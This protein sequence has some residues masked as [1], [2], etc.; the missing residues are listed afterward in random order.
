MNPLPHWASKETLVLT[1][2]VAKSM[3][4]NPLEVGESKQRVVLKVVQSPARAPLQLELT[5]EIW[6]LKGPT[7]AASNRPRNNEFFSCDRYIAF[8]FPLQ[9]CRS[10]IKFLFLLVRCFPKAR[11]RVENTNCQMNTSHGYFVSGQAAPCYLRPDFYH[12]QFA[13][14]RP[15]DRRIYR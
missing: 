6:N 2:E 4:G 15:L 7:K 12:V 3:P 14:M 11:L 8:T 5:L 1:L 13:R 9:D 10:S